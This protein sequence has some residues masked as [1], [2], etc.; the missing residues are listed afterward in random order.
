MIAEL[1]GNRVPQSRI[2]A[3][4]LNIRQADKSTNWMTL[5]EVTVPGA[6]H[7]SPSY[8]REYN[9]AEKLAQMKS[10]VAEM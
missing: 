10:Y 1:S 8:R 2:V 9:P 3:T 4:G 7:L 6:V 5:Q